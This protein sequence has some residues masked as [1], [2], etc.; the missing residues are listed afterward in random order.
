MDKG[1]FVVSLDLELMW[2][3]RDVTT[4]EEYG[5]SIIGVRE[6]LPKM[7]DIFNEFQ[8]NATF[9]TVGFLFFESK[10][11]LLK[12]IPENKPNYKNSNLSPYS[13]IDSIGENERLDPYY[14]GMNLINLI[15]KDNHEIS[16]HTFSHYYCLEDGQNG[17]DFED[18]I[19][20]A[21]NIAKKRGIELKSIIFP[22]NQ[23]N[24][25][26]LQVCK[27]HGIL[28]YRGNESSWIYKASKGDQQ[29]LF[30]R[31]IRLA[32]SY[33]NI[34][35]DNIY[36]YKKIKQTIPLNIPSSAF[37]RPYNKKNSFLESLRLRRIK[38]GMSLAAKKNKVFHLW[39]HPHNFGI[40]QKENLS[41]LNE[42][43]KHYSVLKNK[44]GF[45]SITM[46]SLAD[47]LL[48]EIKT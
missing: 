24:S 18:D 5:N 44:Y 23:F 8:I 3:V 34:T 48:K 1:S 26:Y 10:E 9:A 32:D 46:N 36:D 2:G 43:L 28:S 42:I 20:H 22:R 15:K 31:F 47:K 25:E 17:D 39:W 4:K 27:K 45:Q 6:V 16:T 12:M 29:S 37:L 11:E 35:G 19:I 13:E 7:L 21:I 14:Y 33:I 38:K 40:N 41:F 30:K